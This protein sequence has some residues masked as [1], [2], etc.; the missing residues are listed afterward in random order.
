[1][2]APR[3]IVT[4]AA[5]LIWLGAGGD[6][7]AGDQDCEAV[8]AKIAAQRSDPAP[9]SSSA[10][11]LQPTD[12]RVVYWVDPRRS[13]AELR[14]WGPVRQS[15]GPNAELADVDAPGIPGADGDHTLS[16]VADPLDPRKMAFRHRI[17]PAFPSWLD[18]TWR[19]E[20]TANWSD[21]GSNVVR[22]VDYWVGYAVKFDKDIL[23]ADS[24]EASLL[25]FHVVPDADDRNLTS[26]FHLYINNGAL[27]IQSLSNPNAV[28][29]ARDSVQRILWREEKLGSDVW[30]YFVIKV[31]FHWDERKRPY[32]RIWKA[33]GKGPLKRIVDHAGPNAYN[34]EACYLPQKF[35]LYRWDPFSGETTRTVYT[36]GLYVLRDQPGSPRLNARSLL[37]LL[38]S[39]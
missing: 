17:S 10:A 35:G 1:M 11:R 37:A 36:K 32:L 38:R 24:G 31:R 23:A 39:I 14:R 25:D 3:T 6:L 12:P 15:A 21:D 33:R 7:H 29:D 27:R 22:G 26:P 4:V 16:R 30:H 9:A 5:A 13:F 28:T 18:G 8:A 20:I 34:D 19:S 2:A